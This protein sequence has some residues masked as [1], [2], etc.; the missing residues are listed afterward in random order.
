MDIL[1]LLRQ[2][3]ASYWRVELGRRN[4]NGPNSFNVTLTVRSIVFSNLTGDNIAVLTLSSS[5]R[6]SDYI[7]PICLDTGMDNFLNNADCWMA[8]WGVGQGGGEVPHPER[9]TRSLPSLS[10]PNRLHDGSCVN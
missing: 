2:P 10:P 9:T 7:Q 4:L 1:S 3:N 5:P 8:G 6:L